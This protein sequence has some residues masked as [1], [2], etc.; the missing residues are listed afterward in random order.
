MA[1]SDAAELTRLHSSDQG[2]VR[3]TEC[4]PSAS[5]KALAKANNGQQASD[6]RIAH[7]EAG[8]MQSKSCCPAVLQFH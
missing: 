1:C 8:T 2:E 6:T 7:K 4:W 3:Q 5:A